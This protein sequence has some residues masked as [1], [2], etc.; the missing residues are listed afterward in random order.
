LLQ[1]SLIALPRNHGRGFPATFENRPV[2]CGILRKFTDGNRKTLVRRFDM[3][4][5]IISAVV[6]VLFLFTMAAGSVFAQSTAPLSGKVIETMDSG[7]YTYVCLE[8]DGKKTWLA[9]PQMKVVKGSEMSFQPGVEMS[10][11]KSKTLNRTF[12]S[13]IFSGGPA[14]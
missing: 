11:F 13:I 4:K 9:V 3:K 2:S 8:K 14:K 1:K 12:E 10:N 7:G 5:S 6:V